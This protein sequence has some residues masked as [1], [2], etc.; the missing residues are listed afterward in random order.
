M[1]PYFNFNYVTNPPNDELVNF[2]TQI[3]DNWSELDNK[4]KPFN[5]PGGTI[6]APPIGT[7]APHPLSGIPSVWTGSFWQEPRMSFWE[8]WTM[9]PLRSPRFNI[10][11]FPL[12]YSVNL[13]QRRG[14]LKGRVAYD[15]SSSAWPQG[16]VEMTSDVAFGTMDFKPVNDLGIMQG[17]TAPITGTSSYR[18]AVIWVQTSASP[19]RT[20]VFARFQGND[21][22]GSPNWIDFSGFTWWF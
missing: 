12:M 5:Q 3:N 15:S 9:L 14:I 19:T 22:G 21:S 10:P 20:S 18:G 1:P 16:Y 8:P 13:A 6:V 2:H 4:L 7:E 11:G 17:A